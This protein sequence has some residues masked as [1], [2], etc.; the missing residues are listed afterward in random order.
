MT[1]AWLTKTDI[2][3]AIKKAGIRQRK[4]C[5][6]AY[7]RTKANDSKTGFLRGNNSTGR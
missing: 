6:L 3:P 4:T 5:S 2:A 7:H 1:D